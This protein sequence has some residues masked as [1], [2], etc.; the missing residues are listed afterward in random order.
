MTRPHRRLV[1][2]ALAVLPG[3]CS[4]LLFPSSAAPSLYTLTPASDFPAG[5]RR[6]SWQLLIDVPIAPSALDTERIALSRS[7]TTIDYFANV[8]W[9][10]RGPLMLQ[11]LLVQSFENSGG[12]TAIAR[13]SLALRADYI[14]RPELRHFEAQY[15]AGANPSAVIQIDVQLV[16]MP[17]RSITA[18]RILQASVPAAENQ[19]PAIVTAFDAAFHQV[20]REMVE[21]A[22]AAVP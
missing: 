1:V 5:G 19:V 6:I 18:R 20:A 14:L 3:A 13:E 2:A 7:P 17:D 10:D 21:W 22:L 4:S 9:T 8:S 12:I 15:G 16:K 11:S